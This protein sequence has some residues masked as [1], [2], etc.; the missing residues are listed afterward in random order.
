MSDVFENDMQGKELL[1]SLMNDFPTLTI[2]YK[3]GT[4]CVRMLGFWSGI[5]SKSTGEWVVNEEVKAILPNFS[6]FKKLEP[7]LIAKKPSYRGAYLLV[8]SPT[9]R[10]VYETFDSAHR[11]KN[12]QGFLG[13]IGF[14]DLN[15]EILILGTIEKPENFDKIYER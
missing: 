4:I 15:R 7:E 11:D 8:N 2:E 10:F 5:A 9:E 12:P 6:L 3:N 14:D 1:Q 13:Q